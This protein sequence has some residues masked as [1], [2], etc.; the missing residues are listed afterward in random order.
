LHR[1]VAMRTNRSLVALAPFLALSVLACGGQSA[2]PRSANDV[3]PAP[4]SADTSSDVASIAPE[5]ATTGS[6]PAAP[7]TAM[8]PAPTEAQAPDVAPPSFTDGE[9]LQIA[10]LA[11]EGEIAQ[12]KLAL[13]KGQDPRV[14]K[15]AKMMLEDHAAADAKGTG[16]AKREGLVAADSAASSSLAS[17]AGR[18]TS[19]LRA[20]SG[21]TFDEDYVNTQVKEHQDV[22]SLLD[23]RLLPEAKDP[24]LRAFL[25]EV[26]ARVAMHLQH[27]QS[28]QTTMQR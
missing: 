14:R 7:A 22:L 13:R 5:T 27:A 24:E 18:A 23:G 21:P 8:L 11:N 26:R 20:E 2:P 10:H 25:A 19:T 1:S 28:L 17:D 12:A 3:N 6:A 16:I 15:L 4:T 9:I